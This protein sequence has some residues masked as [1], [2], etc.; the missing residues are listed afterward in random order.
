MLGTFDPH[1]KSQLERKINDHIV[2]HNKIGVNHLEINDI[3]N[4]F[5]DHM[6]EL[7]VQNMQ[8]KMQDDPEN[9]HGAKE[10][11]WQYIVE[12]INDRI[13]NYQLDEKFEYFA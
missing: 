10:L 2:E 8:M 12:I 3:I 5:V 7:Y 11:A 6:A 4:E 9:I 1:G 13:N